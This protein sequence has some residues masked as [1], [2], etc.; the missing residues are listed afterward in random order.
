MTQ[1]EARQQGLHGWV[2]AVC[3]NGVHCIP[4]GDLHDHLDEDCPCRP[5]RDETGV[6]IH[7]SFDG[8]EAFEEGERR[9]S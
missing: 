1:D 4:V 7:N 3:E 2:P 5:V 6:W 8:R 9:P